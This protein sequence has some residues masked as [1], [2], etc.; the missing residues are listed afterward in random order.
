MQPF[1]HFPSFVYSL[2]NTVYK[3]SCALLMAAFKECLAF[4]EQSRSWS[5]LQQLWVDKMRREWTWM[6]QIGWGGR[7][8][9]FEGEKCFMLDFVL[10]ATTEW[11][12]LCQRK[13][14][15][16][17]LI[18]SQLVNLSALITLH[19]YCVALSF[20]WSQTPQEESLPPQDFE[21]QTRI[22]IWAKQTIFNILCSIL[23][24]LF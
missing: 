20:L 15:S 10:W 24:V 4:T 19:Y 3:R 18:K 17:P 23:F 6:A 14:K 11:R 5:L 16:T 8:A 9:Q 2:S 22:N 21:S 12:C 7:T 1:I 13:K